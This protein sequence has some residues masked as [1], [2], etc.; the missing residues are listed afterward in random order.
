ML[1]KLIEFFALPETREIETL[2]CV[3]T[4]QLHSKIILS[5]PFLKKIYLEFYLRYKKIIEL[6]SK[7]AFIELV[8]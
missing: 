7:G 3:E 2:D 4:S 6:N 8:V 1:K 5:K